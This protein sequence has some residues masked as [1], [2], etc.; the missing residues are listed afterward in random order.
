MDLYDKIENKVNINEKEIISIEKGK[1]PFI[2][3]NDSLNK[4]LED[5]QK[6]PEEEHF[7]D[8]KF[9]SNKTFYKNIKPNLEDQKFYQNC[10]LDENNEKKDL[11]NA[12]RK[13]NNDVEKSNSFS[14]VMVK[15]IIFDDQISLN[16]SD[17]LKNNNSP[18]D[19][20]EEKNKISF[21]NLYNRNTLS[22]NK[23]IENY[24]KQY[25]VNNDNKENMKLEG[26]V[27]RNVY[28]YNNNIMYHELYVELLHV[29]KNLQNEIKTLKKIIEM[30][31]ILI[32]SKEIIDDKIDEKK[33]ISNKKFVNNNY[34]LNFFNKKKK[35]KK[36]FPTNKEQSEK[37]F[38]KNSYSK[39]EKIYDIE[40]D[41]KTYFEKIDEKIGSK[42][43]KYIKLPLDENK[44]SE[45]FNQNCPP[46]SSSFFTNKNKEFDN[47]KRENIFSEMEQDLKYESANKK[48]EKNNNSS[49][50]E[51]ISNLIYWYEEILPM[52]KNDKNKKLLISCM[53]N[54]YMPKKIKEYFWELSINNKL[55]LTK[56]F[57]QVLIKNTVFMQSYVYSN[58]KQY[59]NHVIRYFKS[60]KISRDKFLNLNTA[61]TELKH[62][63][64]IEK[65]TNV[66]MGYQNNSLIYENDNNN[67]NEK[68][69]GTNEHTNNE[70][71]N[72]G[73]NN[74]EINSYENHLN[75]NNNN[76]EK[77]ISKNNENNN[78]N[79]N[80][81]TSNSNM[82]L[83]QN[84]SI[85]KFFY[86]ILIDLDRTIYI[87][88]KNQEYFK[89]YNITIDNFILT[90]NLS[91]MKKKLNTLLQMYV[92]F[93]PELGY[94]QGMSYIALIFLLYCDL[95]TAFVHFANFMDKKDI[96]N[97]YSFNKEEIKAYIYTIKEIL[98]KRNIEI[99]KE[100]IK[101]YNIDNIFIQWIF[102]VFFI[103]LPFHIFIRLFDIYTFYDEIIYEIIICIFTYLDK[104]YH[105][106]NIDIV[107]KNLSTFSFNINI[108]EDKFWDLLKITKIKKSKIIHYRK[109]YFDKIN[110]CVNEK[111]ST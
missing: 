28:E 32:E 29:N 65:N 98:L 15:S 38:N 101:H 9:K 27:P 70:T 6:F 75:V 85:E 45:H 57:V 105:F 17:E 5:I 81:D 13:E 7:N 68:E 73:N 34:F 35:K 8:D 20:I 67:N 23:L 54:N 61:E 47:N 12:I 99:Y 50:N 52:I 92:L 33:K 19:T 107:V 77:N 58:N 43:D 59:H 62:N 102:T 64:N 87:L 41:Y 71:N 44:Y 1:I 104:F 18:D 78:K 111:D 74:T 60:L 97:F 94:V 93:K 90:I 63:Y 95:E 40:V 24:L 4:K 84:L 55:N 89:K 53:I 66:Y 31:K 110:N 82:R 88:K 37:C 106:D 42:K 49:K 36:D 72:T 109:K 103:C 51:E 48:E 21:N 108:Q 25:F 2:N 83:F 26:I 39:C 69:D 91:D 16:F 79:N 14:D 22:Q 3:K 96:Y 11:S 80:E 100:I 76:E 10:Y 56:Y 86:Q 30:Q 46:S